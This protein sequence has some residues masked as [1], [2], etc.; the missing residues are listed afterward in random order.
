MMDEVTVNQLT[1]DETPST[2]VTDLGLVV[3][4]AMVTLQ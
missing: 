2:V 1:F 3:A 4:E